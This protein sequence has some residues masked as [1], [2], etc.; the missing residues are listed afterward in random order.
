V[1]GSGSRLHQVIALVLEVLL[2]R[3]SLS[4]SVSV[5]S[6]LLYCTWVLLYKIYLKKKSDIQH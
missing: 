6:A 5:P 3:L 4:T 1:D 2:F